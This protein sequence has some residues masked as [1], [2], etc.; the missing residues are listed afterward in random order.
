MERSGT[1][2]GVPGVFQHLIRSGNKPHEPLPLAGSR[3]YS[4]AESHAGVPALHKHEREW[5]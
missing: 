2:E 4:P 3:A 5:A 1:C